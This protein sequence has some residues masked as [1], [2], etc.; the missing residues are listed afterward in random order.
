MN[1]ALII[2]IKNPVPGRVKTRLAADIGADN[3]LAV[4]H[5]LLD[6]TRNVCSGVEADRFL[7]YSD[8]IETIDNWPENIFTK[9]LQK[10]T[11]DLGERMLSAFEETIKQY[12]KAVIIG[13]DCPGLS[14][15]LIEEAF[16]KL[17]NFDAVI[18]PATDGGYYLLALSKAEK[19]LFQ[20]KEWSTS[21]VLKN[22]INDLEHLDMSYHL[23][24]PHTDVDDLNDLRIVNLPELERFCAE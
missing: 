3:A 8:T 20:H 21:V 1:K 17:D 5:T 7:Y 10:Q 9:R 4:Y 16:G 12:D 19:S 11:P 13:S 18:G 15:E 22:T 6:M 2:F 23:L 24:P 14:T